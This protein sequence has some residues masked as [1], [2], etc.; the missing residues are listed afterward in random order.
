MTTELHKRPTKRSPLPDRST[1][2]I[3]IWLGLFCYVESFIGFFLSKA[4]SHYNSQMSNNL[5]YQLRNFL[6]NEEIV[7]AILI[8]TIGTFAIWNWNLKKNKTT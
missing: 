1:T 2:L 5:K 4:G 8:T 7:V 3:I 6:A